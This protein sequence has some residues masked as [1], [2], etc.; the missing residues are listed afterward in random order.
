MS[1][2]VIPVYEE[3]CDFW[4]DRRGNYHQPRQKYIGHCVINTEKEKVTIKII[5][6]NE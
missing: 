6:H 4:I 1:K 5:K 2:I 3:D